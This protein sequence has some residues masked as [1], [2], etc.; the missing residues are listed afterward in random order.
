MERLREKSTTYL[1]ADF[2]T[3]GPALF[4]PGFAAHYLS[5]L[6]N[7]PVYVTLGARHTPSRHCSITPG[8][9]ICHSGDG[10]SSG[11]HIYPSPSGRPR[12]SALIGP[13]GISCNGPASICPG[14]MI[15]VGNDCMSAPLAAAAQAVSVGR[16]D[17]H[18]PS[19]RAPSAGS[20]VPS[21]VTA[22]V[23]S[24]RPSE[25]RAIS[26]R[27]AAASGAT[28]S[29]SRAYAFSGT[30]SIFYRPHSPIQSV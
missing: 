17:V 25:T 20:I 9:G 2:Q 6:P 21:P 24:D 4:A 28:A 3:A 23:Q 7:G 29:R 27:S 22:S 8:P 16:P 13:S 19:G 12:L 18:A 10:A 14:S 1:S 30:G 26:S 11:V 15:A 5:G